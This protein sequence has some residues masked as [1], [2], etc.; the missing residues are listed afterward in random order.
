M[1]LKTENLAILLTDIAGFTEATIQQ[2]RLDNERL[3]DTHSRLLLPLI[4][5]FK[6]RL[7]K[8]IGD[9][10]LIVF[11][12]PTD[13]MLCAMAMQDGLF[14]YNREQPPER[15]IHIRIAASLGEVRVTRKDIFGEPVN[16]TSRIE[17]ITP[18]DEIYFS[19][20]M[21]MAM[22]KAEVPSQEVGWKE[23]KGVAQPVRIYQVPR[24]GNPRLVAA[25]AMSNQDMSGIAFPFGGAHLSKDHPPD[26]LL[27]QATQ[28]KIGAVRWL[29]THGRRTG[30]AL[31]LVA[32]AGT[33]VFAAMKW[34]PHR[35]VADGATATALATPTPRPAAASA[36]A[37][38]PTVVAPKAAP[39]AAPAKSIATKPAATVAPVA[40][41]SAPVSAPAPAPSTEFTSVRAAKAAYRQDKISRAE[42]RRIVARLQEQ[43]DKEET[44]A[45]EAYR[46]GRID[47]R[48]YRRQR[49][50]INRKY[51]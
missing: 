1:D 30:V 43:M 23:L 47:R 8:T 10:F 17:G 5:R 20:A 29:K 28:M 7:I 27:E 25:D 9:A 44:A 19:E 50:A 39:P 24:F 32:L 26:K 42:Y 4:K 15:Q 49:E 40:V 21:Y 2:S 51:D 11:K 18:A 33:G 22:N 48:E 13:A 38:A 16:I 46:A 34:W 12:S 3:I 36:P 31:A 37:G 45:K 14:A 6:G 35:Q 41:E